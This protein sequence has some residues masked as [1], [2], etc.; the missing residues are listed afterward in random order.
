M[1]SAVKR[2]RFDHEVERDD[3]ERLSADDMAARTTAQMQADALL[4]PRLRAE[5]GE[6]IRRGVCLSCDSQCLPCAVY[7]DAECRTEHEARL[8]AHA[9]HG[10]NFAG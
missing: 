10:S 6:F 9:R 8:R 3:L 7:C 4:A 2:E 1:N 5:R